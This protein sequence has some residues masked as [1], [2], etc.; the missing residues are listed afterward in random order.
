MGTCPLLGGVCVSRKVIDD[1]MHR[2][3]GLG[4]FWW[5]LFGF[6]FPAVIKKSSCST[7]KYL[8]EACLSFISGQHQFI[9]LSG[10][11]ISRS[12]DNKIKKS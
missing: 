3:K 7:R 12:L 1:S 4:W 8:L 6:F 11:I 10:L 9:A 5:S 2:K